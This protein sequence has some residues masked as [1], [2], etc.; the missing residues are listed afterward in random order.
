MSLGKLRRTIPT[1]RGREQIP[2][3]EA[4]V[5]TNHVRSHLRLGKPRSICQRVSQRADIVP[6]LFCR[7]HIGLDVAGLI[8]IF[9]GTLQQSD[10][11]AM[12][13]G[14]GLVIIYKVVQSPCHPLIGIILGHIV[15]VTVDAVGR[16]RHAQ[17]IILQFGAKLDAI[18]QAG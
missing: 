3:F 8:M 7:S 15:A 1:H 5:T 16:I 18:R 10:A 9:R 12:L 4:I 14:N 17:P 13:L 6:Q 11:Y 2:V